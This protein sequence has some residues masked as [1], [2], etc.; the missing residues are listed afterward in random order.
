M[1]ALLGH[2][3]VYVLTDEAL[4]V[5]SAGLCKFSSSINQGGRCLTQL[6]RRLIVGGTAGLSIYDISEERQPS[7]VASQRDYDVAGLMIPPDAPS[8]S[9][10][11]LLVDGSARMFTIHDQQIEESAIYSAPPWFADSIDLGNLFVS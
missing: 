6:G 1:D 7:L 5:R 3:V 9:V 11:A 8:G 2:D 10:L 4:E